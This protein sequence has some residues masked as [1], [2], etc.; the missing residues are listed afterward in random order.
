MKDYVGL[1]KLLVVLSLSFAVGAG[2][3]SWKHGWDARP[4][5]G[6]SGLDTGA[7]R[8]YVDKLEKSAAITDQVEDLI[9]SLEYVL[10]SEPGDRKSMDMLAKSWIAMAVGHARDV[11][12]K[13]EFLRKAMTV[14][15]RSMMLSPAF[16]DAINSFEDSRR[17]VPAAVHALTDDAR[18]AMSTWALAALLYYEDCLSEVLKRTNEDFVDG[19]VQVIEHHYNL[20][21]EDSR[22]FAAELLGL[23]AAVRPGAKMVMVADNFDKAVEAAPNSILI[24]WLRAEYLYASFG[25]KLGRDSAYLTIKAIDLDSASGFMPLNRAILLSVG[26]K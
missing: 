3:I 24:N 20:L 23:A 13:G 25:D 10:A 19:V 4:F 21:P 12:E 6:G 1:G 8:E 26:Q 7:V 14:A 18:C 17:S 22:S 11:P 9:E 5:K 15:E 2:C 16:A